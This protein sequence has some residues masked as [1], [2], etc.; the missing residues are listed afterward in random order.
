MN[1]A[2][3]KGE[4]TVKTLAKRLLAEPTRDRPKTTQAEME[5]ALLRLN[6]QLNQIG[7][8]GKGTPIVVPEEFPLAP[9]ESAVPTRALTDE[10]LRQAEATVATLRTLIKRR[11]DEFTAQTEDVQ[12]WLKT[13]QAKDLV[14]ETPELKEVFS[15]AATA[16]KALPKE[17]AATV[18]AET[19]ALDKVSAQV[20]EF[21]GSWLRQPPAK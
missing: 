14:K 21:R 11:T 8:L 3:L 1:I 16:A 10:L 17:Q 2:E 20:R 19:K 7:E 13:Q 4:K 9:E 12:R 6:P 15:G 18:I 5:A